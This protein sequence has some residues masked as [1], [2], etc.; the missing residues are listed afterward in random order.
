MFWCGPLWVPLVWN[1]L[2]FLDLNFFSFPRL[3]KFSVTVSS[4]KFSTPFSLSSPSKTSTVQIL[5][6][7]M[8]SQRALKCSSF[9]KNFCV[10]VWYPLL[11]LPLICSS[12]P[13]NL[14]LIPSSVVFFSVIIFLS[15]VCFFFVSSN[16]LLKSHCVHP[17]LSRVH[18]ASLW[19]LA[20]TLYQVD[21]IAP[22][23]LV[24]LLRFCLVSSFVTYSSVSPFCLTLCV[25]LYVLGRSL[26][27]NREVTLCRRHPVGPSSTLPS[28]HQSYML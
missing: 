15:S 9:K 4:S 27:Q 5:V 18:W 21:C 3:G 16:S 7:F 24:L 28:G 25:Y 12:V 11:C 14:P 10:C 17:F 8:L 26:L 1:C 22:L 19:S 2:C 23:H 20:W 6:C 13:S